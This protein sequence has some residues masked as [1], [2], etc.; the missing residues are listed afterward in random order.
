MLF[1]Q[2][3]VIHEILTSRDGLGVENIETMSYDTDGFL[4][5][6]GGT[7]SG[8]RII[9]DSESPVL[10][11]FDGSRFHTIIPESLQNIVFIGQLL[12][13]D[14]D[15][16]VVATDTDEVSHLFILDPVAVTTQK[17]DLKGARRMSSMV[18]YGNVYYVLL[19]N[20]REITVAT[21]D[22]DQGITE[23]FSFTKTTNKYLIDDSTQLLIKKDVIIISDD[24]F[25]ISIFTHEGKLLEEVNHPPGASSTGMVWLDEVFT[26][27]DKEY[28]FLFDDDTLF[29]I[30]D[31]GKLSL[32]Q[33]KRAILNNDH[34]GCI[35]DTKGQGRIVSSKGNVITVSKLDS[36]E[37]LTTVYEKALFDNPRHLKLLSS[38]VTQDLWIG[39]GQQELH[40]IK[41]PSTKMKTFLPDEELRALTVLN[42]DEL[43]VATQN[44][45][46]FTLDRISGVTKPYPLS[47]DGVS[48]KPYASRAFI[49]EDD[50]IWSHSFARIIELDTTA[51]S[52][53]SS[54]YYPILNMISP[55]DSTIV[56]GTHQYYLVEYNKNSKTHTHIAKTD[57]LHIYD[58]A[59][60]QDN[61]T[62]VGATDKG[63]LLYDYKNKTSS[64]V[65]DTTKL[66]DSFLLMT[67]YDPDHGFILGSRSGV[68][69]TYD[70]KKKTFT[71]VYEDALKAGIATILF[72]D[73]KNWWINTF[74]GTVFYNPETAVIQRFSTE[75]GLSHNEANRY[76]ALKTDEGFYVGSLQGLTFF[77]PDILEPV[78]VDEKVE[79]L[80][81][82][83]FDAEKKEFKNI[84]NRN[85]F[86]KASPILLPVENRD[87]QLDFSLAGADVLRNERY[88]YSLN[89][90]NWVDLGEAKTLR[91]PNL[92][93]GNY[94]IALQ[95]LDFSGKP[96]G[97]SLKQNI[98]SKQFFY[99]T[100]W[101]YMLLFMAVTTLLVWW[102]WQLQ[103]RKKM[104]EQF[105][106][107]LLSGQ[108]DERARIAKELHDSVGQQLTLIKQ[109]AQNSD[110]PEMASLSNTALE[111]VRTISRNLY[112][113]II[114]QLGITGAIE[115]LMLSIDDGTSLFVSTLVD[116]IDPY[117]TE[118]QSLIMYRF[119]QEAVANVLKHAEA[120]TLSLEIEDEQSA[121]VIHI[122]DN[123][124]GFDAALA[125]KKN[126]LGLKTMEERIKILKGTLEFINHT[127][128]GSH[129]MAKIPKTL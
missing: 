39:T 67:D 120:T 29:E 82:R 57:S 28:A 56:Y 83:L 126:S 1:G 125:L 127:K 71:T 20:D 33:K 15:L 19:Q 12:P 84:W 9:L 3:R 41:F 99:K 111:E 35:T 88:R 110:L 81:V 11:R 13:V 27:D 25:P 8:R 58:L 44:G 18:V 10:Q 77:D 30:S 105:S 65:Q 31:T 42:D 103:L 26:Q 47:L 34:I 17:I 52:V 117:F 80:R 7:A 53:E 115:Q 45:G 94:V 38:D 49:H 128:D 64:I 78:V 119:I 6:G 36:I 16:F 87:I 4:W 96:I 61:Q 46:W 79:L 116:D 97:E 101:F 123:G 106:R 92:E 63:M 60:N 114:S 113:A 100:W 73:D 74:N 40:Y 112:P 90:G 91:F 54:R 59:F 76:S 66:K 5:I 86:A 37:G 109:T 98:R 108:E 23:L 75:D 2:Q 102:L 122:S 95:A 55:T 48:L 118:K 21:V 22:R 89:D 104:D 69:T 129:I 43:L 50:K 24:N 68:I 72:D 62:I 70:S 14:K 121:V 107:D 51:H 93:A 85:A 124:K 32:V